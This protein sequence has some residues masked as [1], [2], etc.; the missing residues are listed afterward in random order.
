[1]AQMNLNFGNNIFK[2]SISA[3][4]KN[5]IR[6]DLN[7]INNKSNHYVKEFN[8]NEFKELNQIFRIYDTLEEIEKDLIK[9]IITENLK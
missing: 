8:L 6:F 2:L 7:C 9:Y 1:M 3:I 5:L 4:D